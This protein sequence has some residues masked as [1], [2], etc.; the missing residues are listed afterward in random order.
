MNF[1]SNTARLGSGGAMYFANSSVTFGAQAAMFFRYNF[2]SSSGGAMYFKNSSAAYFKGGGNTKVEFSNN[3]ANLN[4][5]GAMYFE[6]TPKV[7]FTGIGAMSFIKNSAGLAGSGL[8]GSGGAM[9]F[10]KT[11]AVFSPTSLT[12]SSNTARVHGG[13]MYFTGSTVT[14]NSVLSAMTF[15]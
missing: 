8:I 9:Y 10:D 3:T 14:F 1:T 4:S 5:G 6:G 13:A 7:E 15:N 12:F 11:L 2:S